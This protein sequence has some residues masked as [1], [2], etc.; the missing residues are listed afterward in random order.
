[1]NA[2]KTVLSKLM[3]FR[4]DFQFQRCVDRYKGDV[5]LAL[6]EKTNIKELFSGNNILNKQY[7][8]PFLPLWGN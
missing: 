8:Y 6:L 3:M 4:S 1:M 7:D 5:G 2:G